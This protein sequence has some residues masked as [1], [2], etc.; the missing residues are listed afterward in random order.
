M[1]MTMTAS[2]REIYMQIAVDAVRATER[3][4][5]STAKTNW[6]HKNSACSS[7]IMRMKAFTTA[8]SECKKDTS[9]QKK[10]VLVHR[11]HKA[12]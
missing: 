2:F 1:Q 5:A 6:M 4:M 9:E 11:M 10:I 8:A 7:E 3:S 12:T